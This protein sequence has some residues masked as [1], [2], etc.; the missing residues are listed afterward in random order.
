MLVGTGD[1]DA[2]YYAIIP[3]I[4]TS[5]GAAAQGQKAFASRQTAVEGRQVQEFFIETGI[6]DGKPSTGTESPI[7][8]LTDQERVGIGT[9]DP[10]AKLE[11]LGSVLISGSNTLTN[12]GPAVFS[13]SVDITQGE[14]NIQESLYVIKK[15]SIGTTHQSASL[16][17]SASSEDNAMVI[18]LN[19]GN[20]DTDKFKINDEGIIVLGA[21]N[22]PPTAVA[23]GIYFSSE[24]DYFFGFS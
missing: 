3:K 7:L 1:G 12:I 10:R 18:K 20:G 16:T 13:G 8:T 5:K 11:V 4:Y 21:L 22:S 15:I 24:N 23:G 19:D 9:I 6:I 17:I 14:V 2:S